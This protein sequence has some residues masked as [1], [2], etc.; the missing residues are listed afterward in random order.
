VDGWGWVVGVGGVERERERGE[1]EIRKVTFAG[2]IARHA[3]SLSGQSHS[4]AHISA[5]IKR[6]VR[7]SPTD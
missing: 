5:L 4:A 3:T 1:E 2:W 6:P 7:R